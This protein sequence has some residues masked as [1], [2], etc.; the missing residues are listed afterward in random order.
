MDSSYYSDS[1][2]L[3]KTNKGFLNEKS[4]ICKRMRK[5]IKERIERKQ[6]L[7]QIHEDL[8]Q[9]TEYNQILKHPIDSS[10]QIKGTANAKSSLLNFAFKKK[11]RKR[12]GKGSS[13]VL[14]TEK[15]QTSQFSGRKLNENTK[16]RESTIKYL[17]REE[18]R[19]LSPN[20]KK[21][22]LS[23]LHRC[24]KDK[25]FQGNIRS[26][27]SIRQ[28]SKRPLKVRIK[29]ST[30]LN[31]DT[32]LSHIS[33]KEKMANSISSIIDGLDTTTDPQSLLKKTNISI[34]NRTNEPLIQR[35]SQKLL[36]NI[37]LHYK[38]SNL[39]RN[40]LSPINLISQNKNKSFFGRSSCF[41]RENS[42][43]GMTNNQYNSIQAIKNQSIQKK[44]TEQNLFL[45]SDYILKQRNNL[46]V[47]NAQEEC[48]SPGIKSDIF[49]LVKTINPRKRKS[50]SFRESS[51]FGNQLSPS[52]KRKYSKNRKSMIIKNNTFQQ[53]N[54]SRHDSL[55]RS[56]SVRRNQLRKNKS[57]SRLTR[58]R[59][60]V[61]D[62]F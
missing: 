22:T 33:G 31:L 58:V 46:L 12:F 39:A 5:K 24:L 26:R 11:L 25:F 59:R 4:L 8:I 42:P 19:D 40:N 49:K 27:S 35:R 60:N 51:K 3:V 50:S 43:T 48:I 13:N 2:N 53:I 57:L 41:Y 17:S 38:R 16:N 47:A 36:K 1:G 21:L 30:K 44:K 9:I 54:N 45:L 18:A 29:Q 37:F 52:I 61:L 15:I 7:V 14:S 62:I 55:K 23:D 56:I 32:S 6:K 28:D 20:K 10:G 34:A